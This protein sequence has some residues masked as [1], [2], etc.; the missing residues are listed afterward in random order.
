MKTR[1]RTFC[2]YLFLLLLVSSFFFFLAENTQASSK[3]TVTVQVPSDAPRLHLLGAEFILVEKAKLPDKM[4]I[5]RQRWH[6][7]Y[8]SH[9]KNIFDGESIPLLGPHKSQWQALSQI[10]RKSPHSLKALRNINSFFNRISSRKDKDFY[11]KN[12]HWASPLEFLT[13]RS[14]DCEDYAITK[15]FALKYF[16]WNPEKLWLVFLHDKINVGG[17]AV[18]VAQ[19]DKGQFVLDNLSQPSHLLIPVKQYENQVAPFALANHQGLWLRV[20]GGGEAEALS[21]F[22]PR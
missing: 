2:A 10:T 20:T 17:H 14:G 7:I 8:S 9:E 19:A 22:R 11:G 12:E 4:N 5:M 3:D 15:Y 6:E 21:K 1:N 16:G 13:N 18:L